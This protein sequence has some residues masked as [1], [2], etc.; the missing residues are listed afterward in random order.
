[1]QSLRSLRVGAGDTLLVHGGSGSV[2]QSA[3]QFAVAWGATVIGTT[4]D[5]RA[6]TVRSLDAIPVAYGEGLADRVRQAAPGGIT[7]ALD[8]AG[9]D[10]AIET[11]LELVDDR[12]RIAT[13]VR[14]PEREKW[15][16]RGWGGAD[17]TPR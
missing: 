15:G 11:S 5:R 12:D 17:L 16:I 1:Y 8:T 4:S 3:I 6:D 9:T 10:E 13:I 14:Y 7:V 2:G